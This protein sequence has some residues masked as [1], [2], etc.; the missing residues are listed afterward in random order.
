MTHGAKHCVRSVGK[1]NGTRCGGGLG[2]GV[3]ETEHGISP[4]RVDDGWLTSWRWVLPLRQ[5]RGRAVSTITQRDA[6]R[7]LLIRLGVGSD[8]P[9]FE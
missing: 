7:V 4:L 8:P 6:G 1:E 9:P 2:E 3:L 5:H